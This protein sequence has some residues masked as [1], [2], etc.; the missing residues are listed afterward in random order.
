MSLKHAQFQTVSSLDYSVL[1]TN[2]Q[3]LVSLEDDVAEL[4]LINTTDAIIRVK[5][6]NLIDM[7]VVTTESIRMP[8][9]SSWAFSGRTNH[10]QV[11]KGNIEIAYT[12]TAPTTGEVSM[13]GV[14]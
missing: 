7:A 5:L 11:C 13:G 1:T 6:P 3:T 2:F 9:R 10:K 4:F 14:R 12:G 8:A